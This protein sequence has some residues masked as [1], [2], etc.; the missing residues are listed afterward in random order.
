MPTPSVCDPS[1]QG[2]RGASRPVQKKSTGHVRQLAEF[3]EEPSGRYVP[4]GQ[5]A[6]TTWKKDIAPTVEEAPMKDIQHKLPSPE[7]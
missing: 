4:F 7:R 6:A 5:I 1:G 2:C 3:L